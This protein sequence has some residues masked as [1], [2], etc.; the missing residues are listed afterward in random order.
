MKTNV[1]PD[2]LEVNVTG[3]PNGHGNFPE[4]IY[5]GIVLDQGVL[6]ADLVGKTI[7]FSKVYK[8]IVSKTEVKYYVHKNAVI[9]VVSN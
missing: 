2:Y 8:L 6:G 1:L 5:T 3:F 9:A 4:N 7:L